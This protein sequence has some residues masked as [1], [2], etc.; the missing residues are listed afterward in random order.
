M[1]GENIR[2]RTQRLALNVLDIASE[3][4]R[5]YSSQVLARQV[6]RS[7]T[8]VGAN[9]RAACRS[10]SGRD[11]LNKLKIVEEEL[12]ETMF[13]LELIAARKLA[14][15]EKLAPLIAESNE[16]LAI[17]VKSIVTVKENEKAKAKE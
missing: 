17:I 6:T 16:L 7:A 15:P 13:W 5:D 2:D 12:D 14:L 4:P 11:F 10:K 1:R 9:Y 3:I 8:S